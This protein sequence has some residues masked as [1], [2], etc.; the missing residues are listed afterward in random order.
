MEK[1]ELRNGVLFYIAIKDKQLA[2]FADK[3]IHKAAGGEEYWKNTVKE[4]LSVFSKE[5]WWLV[6]RHLFIKLARH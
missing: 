2:I 5:V 1:T 4:I 6:L 3:G